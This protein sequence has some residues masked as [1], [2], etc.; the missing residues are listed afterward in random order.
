MMFVFI[1]IPQQFMVP[2]GIGGL[3][4]SILAG[5]VAALV[6]KPITGTEAAN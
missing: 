5:A 1:P 2:W 3:L 6:Y 4:S